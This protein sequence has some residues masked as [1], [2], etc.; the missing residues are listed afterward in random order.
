MVTTYRF[1]SMESRDASSLKRHNTHFW[2]VI[3]LLMV[4]IIVLAALLCTKIQ[5]YDNSIMTFLSFTGTLLSIVLSI[6]AIMYSFYSMQEAFRQWS[7]VT[8]AVGIIN[9]ST[10]TINRS[11][12]QLLEQIIN[13]NKDLGAMKHNIEVGNE[14]P[15]RE[16][17]TTD[18]R[19][20]ITN[21]R[22]KSDDMLFS[23]RRVIPRN[24]DE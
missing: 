15:P 20:I 7:E 5:E 16:K 6:F 11:T 24:G 10:D 13:I 1:N 9:I 23:R 21:V 14:I 8:N 19:P 17:E 2:W 22:R 18:N 12:Q 4:V 3:C